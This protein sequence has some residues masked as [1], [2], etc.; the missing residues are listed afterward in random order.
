MGQ[1]TYSPTSQ[2]HR[3]HPLPDLGHLCRKQFLHFLPLILLL[4]DQFLSPT[5][6]SDRVRMQGPLEKEVTKSMPR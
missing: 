3:I 2:G 1:L 6:F 5:I 4:G